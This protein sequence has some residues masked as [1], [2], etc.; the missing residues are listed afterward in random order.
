MV[1]GEETE[2]LEARL[3]KR[4]PGAGCEIQTTTVQAFPDAFQAQFS[5]KQSCE[6]SKLSG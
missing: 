5:E 2:A 6:I 3:L 1:E 4:R